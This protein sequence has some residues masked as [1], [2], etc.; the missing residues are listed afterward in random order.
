[1]DNGRTEDLVY[2][3]T[4]KSAVKEV[5]RALAAAVREVADRTAHADCLLALNQLFNPM[6][7]HAFSKD[8]L[9]RLGGLEATQVVLADPR[10]SPAAKEQA[11]KLLWALC[12]NDKPAQDHAASLGL[13]PVVVELIAR[14]G[15]V[16]KS[17]VTPGLRLW[18]V[19][20]LRVAGGTVLPLAHPPHSCFFF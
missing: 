8:D 10:S 3:C 7:T 12:T 14:Q 15:P 9:V 16:M 19:C 18:L 4:D 20:A 6:G 1:M 5:V 17:G 11:A 13:I 2:G